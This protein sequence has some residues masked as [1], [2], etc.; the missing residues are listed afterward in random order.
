V[1]RQI[2]VGLSFE[3][4]KATKTCNPISR[5]TRCEPVSEYALSKFFAT[6]YLIYF[7]I[8]YSVNILFFHIFNLHD[9]YGGR[10]RLIPEIHLNAIR[11]KKNHIK[12]PIVSKDFIHID[13]MAEAFQIALFDRDIRTNLNILILARVQ[14]PP[15]HKLPHSSIILMEIGQ[16]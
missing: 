15:S 14:L 11:G 4:G 6:D 2:P 13:D 10:D 7:S 16:K 9:L 12:T 8:R 1:S 5:N 3:F